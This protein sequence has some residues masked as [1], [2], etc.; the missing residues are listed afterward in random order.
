MAQSANEKEV[1]SCKVYY[2]IDQ[3]LASIYCL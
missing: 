3:Q 1:D 2:V